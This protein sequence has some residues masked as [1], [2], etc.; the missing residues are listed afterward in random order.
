MLSKINKTY[1][2]LIIIVLLVLLLIMLIFGYNSFK[3]YSFKE[4][5][6]IDL[7]ENELIFQDY[8]Y[9]LPEG[10]KSND[11]DSSTLNINTSGVINGVSFH[12]GANIYIEKIS[13]TGK[14][15]EELFNDITFFEKSLH[16]NW[17][18][19][20]IGE[21]Q[22]IQV[23]DTSIFTFP[24]EFGDSSKVLLAYMPAYGG[25]FYDIQFYSNMIIDGKEE[26]VFN[27]QDLS[28]VADFLNSRVKK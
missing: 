17:E 12:K 6:K 19:N 27:Y 21:G 7:K 10:W 25:Y 8:I 20:V 11:K 1:K 5:K 13:S 2:I 16:K 26:M 28:I 18:S 22:I 3:R 23:G 24:C 14:S 9:K 15:K 4:A